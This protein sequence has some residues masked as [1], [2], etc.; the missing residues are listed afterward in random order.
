MTPLSALPHTPFADFQ[1]HFYGAAL[2]LRE[3]V[4]ADG[5]TFLAQY[6]AGPDAAG[7]GAPADWE[8]AVRAWEAGRRFPLARLATEAGV[9]HDG[10]RALLLVGLVE[11][12][13]RFGA[14]FEP[15]TGCPRPTPGLLH[16]W[17]P[18]LRAPLRRLTELG[19]V[20]ACDA[21]TPRA[22]SPLRIPPVVLDAVR[23]DPPGRLAEWVRHRP[24]RELTPLAELIHPEPLLRDLR[25]APA[26]LRAGAARAVIVRGPEAGGRR[27]ALGAIARAA[28]WGMLEVQ[29]LARDD[30]RG[31]P[32]GALATL[33]GAL[34]VIVLDVAPGATVDVPTPDGWAG[35]LGLVAGRTGGV[36]GSA[37][38]QAIVIAIGVPDVDARARHWRA[39]LPGAPAAEL[40]SR[41]RMTGGNIRRTASL[42]SAQAA[43]AGRD[44]P[45]TADVACGA[46]ALQG[47]LLETLAARV[48]TEREWDRVAVRPET[49]DEL[50]LLEARCRQRERVGAVLGPAAADAGP[51]VRALLTGPSGTGKTLAARTLAGVLGVDLYR[52]DLSRVVNKYLGETEK[53][54]D[55]LLSRAEEADAALLLDEGDALMTKRT[56][57]QTSNDRYANLETNFLLQ[58]LESFGGLLVVTSN[59]GERI[60]DAFRRRMDVIIDF[61]PPDELERWSIWRL[62][63]PTE[64]AVSDELLEELSISCA[65][66][67]AQMRNAVVH[68][69]LIAL[70]RGGVLDS[71]DLED[72]VRREYRKTGR[73]CPL[74]AEEAPV[75]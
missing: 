69:A 3:H 36:T 23:G 10:L 17:W 11:E 70:E 50:R 20:E 45:V 12:D 66:T 67:G 54:L 1:V 43:L 14:V 32:L 15:L 51:G 13:A 31:R 8:A 5:L 26:V 46:R 37:L 47:R 30:P 74:A 18:E 63:L 42:A 6:C 59:A 57:V 4:A 71:A 56:D 7:L 9:G 41:Y 33:L 72:G 44:E 16:A 73:L 68:A 38:D 35:P 40:A 48:A 75:G 53:N 62:H 25:R 22:D 49:M 58:R 55:R 27:T 29:G 21:D 61:G 34:P 60:D 19:V 24:E 2:R 52:I 64:H 39:A 65:L 28:G